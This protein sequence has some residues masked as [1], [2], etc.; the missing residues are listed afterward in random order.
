MPDVSL[1]STVVVGDVVCT[2]EVSDSGGSVAG[3]S[4]VVDPMP[5]DVSTCPTVPVLDTSL[6]AGAPANIDLA[7][8][9]T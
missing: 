2:T 5:S 4:H 9:C 3:V 6:Y 1:S 7:D 8:I